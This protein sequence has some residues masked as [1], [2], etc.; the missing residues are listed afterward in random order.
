MIIRAIIVDDEWL[1]RKRLHQLLE[2]YEDIR[3][4]GQC[5]D[6][7]EA[8][9]QIQQMEPDLI[10]LDVQ[11]PEL[12]GFG[13]LKQLS[14]KQPPEIIFTTAFDQY[15]IKAFEVAAI[16]YL[17]KPFD[18]ERLKESL[19]RVRNRLNMVQ[20]S[21]FHQQLLQLVQSYQQKSGDQL[22]SLEIKE[23]GRSLNLPIESIYYI[24]SDGNYVALHTK[25]R[26]YLYRITLSTIMEQ[27][28][29]GEFLRI[30]RSY[31]INMRY[32]KSHHYLNNNEF[33]FKLKNGITL[34]SGKSFKTQIVAFLNQEDR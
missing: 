20:T 16:D 6:G 15:A 3:V 27:F 24:K 34:I 1:S 13:V 17:L 26:K 4:I 28:P 10:F 5:R 23:K 33:K 25:D 19:S 29:T 32:V 12:D 18:D 9:E 22:Y 7:K 31:V 8:I 11:M 21:G 2:P 14:L 30:H